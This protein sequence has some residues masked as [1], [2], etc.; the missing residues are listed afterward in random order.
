M[1]HRPLKLY[2]KLA[3]HSPDSAPSRPGFK[4]KLTNNGL[5]PSAWPRS[6][7]L[8][9]QVVNFI[10]PG[11]RI[12]LTGPSHTLGALSP[13]GRRLVVLVANPGAEVATH[14]F[15]LARFPTSTAVRAYRTSGPDGGETLA[16]SPAGAFS[17]D[18][19]IL[20]CAA[21]AYS[22]TTLVI[23]FPAKSRSRLA[24]RH[25]P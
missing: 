24:L 13:D 17:L 5:T 18:A 10:P 15:D 3:R 23:E 4:K 2:P 20:A 19:R 11:Y 25:H 14:R 16:E 6:Y 12:L 21:P 22:L 7:F 1:I 9:K 8:R